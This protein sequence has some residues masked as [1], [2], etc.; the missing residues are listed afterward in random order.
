MHFDFIFVG[1]GPTSLE[2]LK[3]LLIIKPLA[4][5]AVVS[6]DVFWEGPAS[7][8]NQNKVTKTQILQTKSTE[9]YPQEFMAE[10]SEAFFWGTS[11]L[12]LR[13]IG[14]NNSITRAYFEKYKQICVS[15]EVQAERDNLSHVYP[16][17]GEQLG[18]LKRKK[19]AATLVSGSNI[20][21]NWVMGHSRLALSANGRNA[22]TSKGQCF[23]GCPVN[24]PWNPS[25]LAKIIAKKNV[26]VTWLNNTVKHILQQKNSWLIELNEKQFLETE[27]LILGAGWKTNMKLLQQIP[28][29][30]NEI[31][32][33]NLLGANVVLFPI[34]I[35]KRTQNSD[36]Y[37][38]FFF[39]DVFI[40]A[41]NRD[42]T[43]QIYLPTI[44]IYRRIISELPSPLQQMI[45]RYLT[46]LGE[47]IVA[48][49]FG[50]AMVFLPASDLNTDAKITKSQFHDFAKITRKFLKPIG[51]RLILIGAKKIEPRDSYHV[52]CLKILGETGMSLLKGDDGVK[53][54]LPGLHVIGPL[55]LPFVQAG[56]H[57]ISA[58]V[59]SKMY[60]EEIFR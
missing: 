60:I 38:S 50:I 54:L 14:E 47:K 56:P 45:K 21:E 46:F 26:N 6:P 52:G 51:G 13:K 41:K 9:K 55:L 37:S 19:L 7:E 28:K 48:R 18:K 29:L 30:E 10:R 39:H 43:A 16:I 33:Q 12:P 20:D 25:K 3:S 34:L 15:W 27:N 53:P 57:T 17:T 4:K 2:A 42:L 49:H 22:C 59:I 23:S 31:K 8:Q 11:C 36:F 40:S 35:K 24:S 44:E 32:Y 1:A 5:I 58:A